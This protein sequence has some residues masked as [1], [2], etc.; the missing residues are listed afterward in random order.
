MLTLALI[1]LIGGLVTGISPC[2]L[3][4][5]P[6]IF[7]SGGVQS[8]QPSARPEPNGGGVATA[9]APVEAKPPRSR[10]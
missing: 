9:E 8:P 3:P 7:L 10:P 5:L 6:V 1:G 4:V 2:I